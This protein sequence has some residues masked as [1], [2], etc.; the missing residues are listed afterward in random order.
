[1]TAL[2]WFGVG[3]AVA[4]LLRPRVNARARTERPAPAAPRSRPAAPRSTGTGR[5]VL[6]AVRAVNDV[7]AIS[8]G[9]GA[10]SKRLLR[11]QVFRT[12]RRW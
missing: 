10:Y 1:M 6:R 9:P 12:L 7:R 8:R 4:M 5:T 3:F 11:R 2:V